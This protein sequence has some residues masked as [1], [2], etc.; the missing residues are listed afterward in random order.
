MTAVSAAE[1]VTRKYA[2][3]FT[4]FAFVR[5]IVVAGPL[6]VAPL[7]AKRLVKFVVALFEV[8]AI[9]SLTPS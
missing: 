1:L 4:K 2:T 6:I 5:E 7:E 3:P 9:V 8:N